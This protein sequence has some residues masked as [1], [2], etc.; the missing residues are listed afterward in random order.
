MEPPSIITNL[1]VFEGSAI[2]PLI[3]RDLVLILVNNQIH[4]D[5]ERKIDPRQVDGQPQEPPLE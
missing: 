4:D 5:W 1:L 3:S 2:K